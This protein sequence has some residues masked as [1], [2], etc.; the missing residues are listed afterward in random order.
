MNEFYELFILRPTIFIFV[1][2]IYIYFFF[3]CLMHLFS[4]VYVIYLLI[5]SRVK[6][7]GLSV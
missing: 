7:V 1:F 4:F 3:L 2:I 5:C 6:H